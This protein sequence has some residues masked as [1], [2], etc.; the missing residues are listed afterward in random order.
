MGE[1]DP[2]SP[3]TIAPNTLPKA[4]PTMVSNSV[5]GAE[6]RLLMNRKYTNR[7]MIAIDPAAFSWQ[8]VQG[9]PTVSLGIPIVPTAVNEDTHRPDEG[10]TLHGRNLILG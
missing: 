6:H 3:V 9:D 10:W 2:F 5:T 7:N 1:H 8:N 4:T